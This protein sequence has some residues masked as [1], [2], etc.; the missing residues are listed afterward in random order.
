M[1]QDIGIINNLKIEDLYRRQ[2]L[3]DDNRSY[4]V[5]VLDIARQEEYTA[6]RKQD[7]RDGEGSVTAYSVAPRSSFFACVTNPYNQICSIREPGVS[8]SDLYIP[9]QKYP[10]PIILV[11]T[12]CE[13][14]TQH[15]VSI[16]EGST[17]TRELECDFV[18]VSAKNHVNVEN[19]FYNSV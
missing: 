15:E 1:S 10:S 19:M 6:L 8:S 7:I 12:H 5:N 18:E 11:G 2:V 4:Y 9:G 14:P 3:M 13:R 17:L 16:Q